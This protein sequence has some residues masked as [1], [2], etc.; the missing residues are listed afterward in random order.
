MPR[1]TRPLAFLAPAA[2]LIV[3]SRML[4]APN[5]L[6]DDFDHVTHLVDHP[7]RLR[8]V[9][10]F[11]RVTRPLEA[12]AAHRRAMVPTRPRNAFG[13][14][15]LDHFRLC[16]VSAAGPPQGLTSPLWGQR[17]KRAWGSCHPSPRE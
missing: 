16:H 13:E 5:P 8:R 7:A 1:P 10:H 4:C 2:G 17:A 9:D 11:N 6:I 3:L 15:D 12:E 14:R